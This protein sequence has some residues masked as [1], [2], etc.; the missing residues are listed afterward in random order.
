MHVLSNAPRY[1]DTFEVAQGLSMYLVEEVACLLKSH[2]QQMSNHPPTFAVYEYLAGLSG[3][4]EGLF[5][6]RV[7][8]ILT[9]KVCTVVLYILL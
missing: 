3:G 4:Y 5:L 7:L 6:L 2:A 8:D 1:G 9:R